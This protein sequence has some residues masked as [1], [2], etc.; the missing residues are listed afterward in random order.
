LILNGA[1]PNA[2]SESEDDFKSWCAIHLAAE[3][4][5][6]DIANALLKNSAD[7]LFANPKGG[8]PCSLGIAF[9][10]L[11]TAVWFVEET[12]AEIRKTSKP[13]EIAGAIESILDKCMGCACVSGDVAKVDSIFNI[14]LRELDKDLRKGRLHRTVE[15][16]RVEATKY[17]LNPGFDLNG[18]GG[19]GALALEKEFWKLEPFHKRPGNNIVDYHECRKL[20]REAFDLEKARTAVK[21]PKKKKH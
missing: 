4:S 8:R 9:N 7:I 3:Q 1:N 13:G 10:K 5:G 6:V 11:T 16:G 19:D 17:L 21:R 12:I 20:V 2:H 15:C 14:G 18:P